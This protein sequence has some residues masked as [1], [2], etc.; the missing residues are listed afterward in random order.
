M[1][2]TSRENSPA[3]AGGA[4]VADD[5][6]ALGT[7]LRLLGVALVVLAGLAWSG[8]AQV[9][10]AGAAATAGVVVF[11]LPAVRRRQHAELRAQLGAQVEEAR[12]RLHSET[13]MSS[14]LLDVANTLSSTLETSELLQ[15]LNATSR[16]ELHAEWSATFLVDAVAQ[17]FRLVAASDGERRD[18]RRGGRGRVPDGVVA[19]RCTG[20]TREPRHRADGRRGRAGVRDLR[21]RDRTVA[22]V[23][24]TA[25]H[26]GACPRGLHRGRLRHARHLRARASDPLPRGHRRSTRPSCCATRGSSRRCATRATSSRSSSAPSR[27]S[28]ARRSTSMLGYLEM[29]LDGGARPAHRRAGRRARAYA[30]AVARAPRDDHRA[31]RPEPPRGG[32]AAGAAERRS[33]S[34]RC[35]TRSCDQLPEDWRRPQVELRVRGRARPRHRS[36]PTRRS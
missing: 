32:P 7:A 26:R 29:M 25:L 19:S 23:L 18:G 22:S 10:F 24:V 15:R 20:S 31:P 33:R 1:A 30:P 8:V 4:G 9:A 16:D 35:S 21:Q 6:P 2:S 28:C 5:A 3:A 36:R 27:T 17:R 14:A 12:Q 34:G 11:F 13:R